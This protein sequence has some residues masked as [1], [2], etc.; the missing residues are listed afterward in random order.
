MKHVKLITTLGG[1]EN[2]VRYAEIT[3]V[4]QTH[5][6]D[7]FG[8]KGDGFVRGDVGLFCRYSPEYRTKPDDEA[9]RATKHTLYMLGITKEGRKLRIPASAWPALRRA[10]EQYNEWGASQ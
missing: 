3:F 7:K 10:V 9:K 8:D 1:Y 4:Q 5:R 6:S 2:G